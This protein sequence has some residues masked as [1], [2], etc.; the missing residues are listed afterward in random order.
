MEDMPLDQKRFDNARQALESTYRTANVAFRSVPGIVIDWE[1]LGLDKDPRQDRFPIIKDASIDTL[2]EFYEKEI[3][4]RT[5]L[6]SIVGDSSK[7]DME[8]LAKF[9][10]ITTVEADEIFSE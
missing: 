9:G 7:I 2:K 3:Q 10:E 1:N 6:I 5:K 8:A 4:P